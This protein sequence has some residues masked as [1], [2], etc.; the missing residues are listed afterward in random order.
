M[1]ITLCGDDASQPFLL[2]VTKCGCVVDCLVFPGLVLVVGSSVSL[3][4]TSGLVSIDLVR[5]AQ[6]I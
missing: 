4:S 1:R 2:D 6:K 5:L 3:D